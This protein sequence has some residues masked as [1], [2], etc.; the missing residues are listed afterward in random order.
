MDAALKFSLCAFRA[1]PLWIVVLAF[2]LS[3]LFFGNVGFAGQTAVPRKDSHPALS[4]QH[5]APKREPHLANIRQLT[6]GRKNAEAYFSFDGDQLIFQST[7]NWATAGGAGPE[8]GGGVEGGGLS[9]YQMYIMDVASREV[10]LVSTGLGGTTCGYFYPGGRRVLYS[11][12]HLSGPNCPPKPP[13][14][15]RYRWALHDYEIFSARLDGQQVQRLTVAPGYDA[16]AT[17]S[18]D[19]RKI[20]FTSMRD[21]D[22]ELYTMSLDGTRLKRLTHEVGYD[23]GAFFSPDS[24][25]IVYRASH[26]KAEAELAAYQDLLKQNLVEPGQLEIFVMNADGSGKKQVT[27]NGASN[28]APFFHPDGRR[29]IFSSNQQDRQPGKGSRSGR[30]TFQLHLI[31]DDGKG[32]EQ[33]TFLGRFNSFPMFSPDGKQLVWVSD[34]H[35]TK[36]GEFNIFLADWMP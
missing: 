8:A 23:G 20:V 12:T 2:V 3:G 29:I 9:C 25:R 15:K 26:P 27:S 32:L 28:F 14:G 11:S 1:L 16:E 36:Q 13:R 10:R 7:N 24:R 5:S 35:A 17:I 18:P 6:F 34:R 21:G 19:G 31:G 33:I 4:T 30:P 22:L